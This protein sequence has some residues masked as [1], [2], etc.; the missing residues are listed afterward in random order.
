MA[1]YAVGVFMNIVMKY[2]FPFILLKVLPLI[3]VLETNSH[4]SVESSMKRAPGS[5]T[6]K[7]CETGTKVPDGV[8]YVHGM[9]L[10]SARL[11]HDGAH[12]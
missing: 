10:F 2:H 12:I 7:N 5:R 6:L 4:Y 11:I 9:S 1:T 8:L 3:R